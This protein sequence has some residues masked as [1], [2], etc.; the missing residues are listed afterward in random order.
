MPLIF[1][2]GD[3]DGDLIASKVVES[4]ADFSLCSRDSLLVWYHIL[5]ALLVLCFFLI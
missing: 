2:P 4:D 5:L 1:V 3:T